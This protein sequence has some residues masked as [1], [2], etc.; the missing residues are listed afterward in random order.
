LPVQVFPVVPFLPKHAGTRCL[1][2]HASIFETC[3]PLNALPAYAFFLRYTS[4]YC[5]SPP[6]SVGNWARLTFGTIRVLC[7]V[8]CSYSRHPLSSLMSSSSFC[9]TFRQPLPANSTTRHFD[10]LHK[11]TARIITTEIASSVPISQQSSTSM[12]PP[13]TWRR[14]DQR[15]L[16]CTSSPEFRERSLTRRIPSFE[17]DL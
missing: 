10:H 9:S 1:Q 7:G 8:R 15:L 16:V 17:M 3:A 2:S 4:T 6:A 13:A 12:P 5:A 14:I 11:D